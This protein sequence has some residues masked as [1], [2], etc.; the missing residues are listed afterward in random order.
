MDTDTFIQSYFDSLKTQN[1]TNIV[2]WDKLIQNVKKNNFIP[3]EH[4]DNLE[5]ALTANLSILDERELLDLYRETE[6]G[7]TLN[8]EN[9]TFSV[10]FLKMVLKEVL[11]DIITA[12]AWEQADLSQ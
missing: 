8:E 6:Q 1:K 10:E 3:Q 5:K 9:E 12:I 7:S 4:Y 11:M 2:Q